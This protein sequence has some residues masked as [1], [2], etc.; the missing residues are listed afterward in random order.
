MMRRIALLG[1]TIALA[2]LLHASEGE[3]KLVACPPELAME[4]H[5]L[6]AHEMQFF[7]PKEP[8]GTV[9]SHAVVAMIRDRAVT[10]AVAI[11]SAKADAKAPDLLRLDFSGKA[12]FAGA[13]VAPLKAKRDEDGDVSAIIGPATIEV[14]RDGKSFPVLVRGSYHKSPSYRWINLDL[15]SAAEGRLA[16]GAKTYAVRVVDGDGDLVLGTKAKALRA[17]PGV[18]GIEPCDSLAIDTG[19]GSFGP[20]VLKAYYGQPVLVDGAWYD[21]ELSGDGT[22]LTARPSALETATLKV[23]HERWSAKLAGERYILNLSGSAQ[24][25]AIPADR[26]TVI[27]FQQTIPGERTEGRDAWKGR[28]TSGR[29]DLWEGKGKTFEAAAGKTVELAIGAPLTASIATSIRGKAVRMDFNLAD[30]AG[31][32]AELFLPETGPPTPE[33]EVFDAGGKSVYSAKFQFG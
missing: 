7:K 32:R 23:G 29:R 14:K 27:E 25:I 16:F 12:D 31:L 20:S 18:A 3:A 33:V 19:D 10:L 13:P 4:H 1:V 6:S 11:D 17:G 8:K 28:L 24:P 9:S 22:R 5:G 15:G 30:A 2:P 21:V 26:Y